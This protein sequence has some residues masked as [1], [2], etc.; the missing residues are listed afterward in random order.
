MKL[1]I[2][3]LVIGLLIAGFGVFLWDPGSSARY[4]L[5]PYNELQDV[6]LY[7]AIGK[8]LTV[9]GGGLSIGGIVRMIVKR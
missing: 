1:G 7:M 6:A 2:F 3:M 9:I 8:V 4:L 5:E